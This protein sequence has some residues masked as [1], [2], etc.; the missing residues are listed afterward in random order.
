M[1]IGRC[2]KCRFWE[3]GYCEQFGL[4]IPS[5]RSACWDALPKIFERSKINGQSYF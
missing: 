2:G 4:I 5:Y 1:Y 3:F